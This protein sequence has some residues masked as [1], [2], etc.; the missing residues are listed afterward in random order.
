M[1]I[2][3]GG[4]GRGTSF[5]RKVNVSRSEVTLYMNTRKKSP[6]PVTQLIAF[7]L[8]KTDCWE[9]LDR[10]PLRGGEG[11]QDEGSWDITLQWDRVKA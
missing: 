5:V 10:I 6:A 1:Y 7:A 3:R 2:C 4:R 11:D 9:D 8:P